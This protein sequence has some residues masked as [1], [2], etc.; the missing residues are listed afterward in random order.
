MVDGIIIA[1]DVKD[2]AQLEH[3]VI[4][5]SDIP[6]VHGYKIGFT[7]A[8]KYGLVSVVEFIRDLTQEHPVR[9]IY[10]HQKAGND[11]PEMGEAF[12]EL[13]EDADVDDVILFPFTGCET[14]RQWIQACYRRHLN[15]LFGCI[16]TH[17]GFFT[18]DGGIISPTNVLSSLDI[19]IDEGVSDYIFPGVFQNAE[20]QSLTVKALNKVKASRHALFIYTPGIGAQG[21]TTNC[22]EQV[23]DLRPNDIYIPIVGRAI[24]TSKDMRQ[25]TLTLIGE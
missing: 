18:S 4:A 14:T 9:V 15:V 22:F 21:G 7:L 3:L 19:A 2:L 16:M 6:K 24:Y 23:A 11:I 8:L 20:I 1:A 25:A 17:K 10:D 13:M 5:T 12:A